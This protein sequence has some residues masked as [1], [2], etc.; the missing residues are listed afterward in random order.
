MERRRIHLADLAGEVSRLRQ[1]LASIDAEI[2]AFRREIISLQVY[3][4][5]DDSSFDVKEA[6]GAEMAHLAHLRSNTQANLAAAQQIW[7]EV[8]SQS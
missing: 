6:I 8:R 1:E 4:K 7:T 3:A 2:R 5:N